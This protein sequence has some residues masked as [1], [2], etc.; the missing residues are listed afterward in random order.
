MTSTEN[1][2]TDIGTGTG[3][4]ANSFRE[5]IDRKIAMLNGRIKNVEGDLQN[6]KIDADKMATYAVV[7]NRTCRY[8]DYANRREAEFFAKNLI[9]LD[10]DKITDEETNK[11]PKKVA[12]INEK[13]V[14]KI[15]ED[16]EV[17]VDTSGINIKF[18]QVSNITRLYGKPW[19]GKNKNDAPKYAGKDRLRVTLFSNHMR[20]A[21]IRC[22]Q[23]CG[24]EN[25][26]PETSFND[27]NFTDFLYQEKRK[28]NADPDGTHWWYVADGRLIRGKK[29]KPEDKYNPEKAGN[30]PRNRR[31]RDGNGGG[32]FNYGFP[33]NIGHDFDPGNVNNYG[34]SSQEPD[35]GSSNQ[36]NQANGGNTNY[37]SRISRNEV[38]DVINRAVGKKDV[39]N[40]RITKERVTG[41]CHSI[42][43]I[44]KQTT[45]RPQLSKSP[46][47]ENNFKYFESTPNS[48]PPQKRRPRQ[49][50]TRS[51]DRP[52]IP[53]RQSERLLNKGVSQ[54]LEEKAAKAREDYQKRLEKWK[55]NPTQDDQVQL[56]TMA[57]IDQLFENRSTTKEK[58]TSSQRSPKDERNTAAK[59]EENEP[60]DQKDVGDPKDKIKVINSTIPSKKINSSDDKNDTEE[61]EEDEDEDV[62]S[63]IESIYDDSGDDSQGGNDGSTLENV[64]QFDEDDVDAANDQNK[65][66]KEKESTYGSIPSCSQSSL[67]LKKS[68]VGPGCITPEELFQ[69]IA[70]KFEEIYRPKCI[71]RK[72]LFEQFLHDIYG[73]HFLFAHCEDLK[74]RKKIKE[75]CNESLTF[76]K[77]IL[78][79]TDFKASSKYN[80]ESIQEKSSK[81]GQGLDMPISFS[82]IC[83]GTSYIMKRQELLNSAKTEEEKNSI[84]A[85]L[86][87]SIDGRTSLMNQSLIDDIF[88]D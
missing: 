35:P 18:F 39:N 67:V 81:I 40:A 47:R 16:I 22:A 74:E 71:G 84:R 19:D 3:N 72:K 65:I 70:E 87:K 8:A 80:L 10:V 29:R 69:Q 11:D 46:V 41:R 86:N 54:S 5:I 13:V 17:P 64:L 36:G 59:V 83:A 31:R 85:K 60:A 32:G 26:V 20:E 25:V 7:E 34:G 15:I 38:W 79:L 49:R 76:V 37:N 61:E 82:T 63:G 23:Y 24:V 66:P 57:R 30:A 33:D 27:R 4:E 45:I 78:E 2:D 28:L 68:L 21:W 1:M 42:G 43:R 55:I 6:V 52:L 48:R 50:R 53:T 88:E 9:I 73:L 51:F 14:K 62:K 77:D 75:W 56:D 58:R 44:E 12:D